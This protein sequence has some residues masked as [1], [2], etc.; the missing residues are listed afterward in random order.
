MVI[1]ESGQSG[2]AA[3]P[4]VGAGAPEGAPAAASTETAPS[5][6]GL[7]AKAEELAAAKPSEEDPGEIDPATVTGDKHGE[8]GEGEEPAK[9]ADEYI[10][11]LK[12]K[13]LD[14]EKE[15]PEFLKGAIKDAETEKQVRELFEKA[16]GLDIVKP[17]YTELKQE[18]T[19]LREKFG[20]VMGGLEHVRD[21]YNRGDYD[22]FFQKMQIPF[23]TLL[24]YVAEK[25]QYQELPPEQ[26]RVIDARKH[27]DR[28]AYANENRATDL[29]SRLY[30]QSVDMK[31]QMLEL[32]LE[33]ADVKSFAQTFEE[34]T[35][36][37]FRDAVIDHGEAAH[38]N[39]SLDLSPQQV[40]QELMSHYG[41]L[42][43]PA[44][45][46]TAPAAQGQAQPGTPPASAPTRQ[47]PVI[48]NVSGRQT[49]PTGNSKPKNL[50]DLRK[51]RSEMMAAQVQGQS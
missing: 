50:D 32:A 48:P 47:P 3:E 41:K 25:I 42:L 11:N 7:R 19:Q 4:E 30:Q 35:G 40:I 17:K 21:L 26:Q 45:A 16:D 23:N 8:P 46:P 14:Q 10:A 36:K 18:H 34:K 6:E 51:I 43:T 5:I 9:T 1:K 29:E 38:V 12:Y 28:E 27:S 33:R 37:S 20:N 44:P 22:G 15:F 2:S 31:G 39:R 49:S 24:Q 13:V